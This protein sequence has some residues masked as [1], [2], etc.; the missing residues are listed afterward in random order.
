MPAAPG[1]NQSHGGAFCVLAEGAA[2]FCAK[3]LRSLKIVNEIVHCNV[4]HYGV[5]RY[6]IQIYV[7]KK[8]HPQ[9]LQV[10]GAFL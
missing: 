2:F 9:L 8:E 6:I 5:W 4:W 7:Y 3:R 1:K 10:E